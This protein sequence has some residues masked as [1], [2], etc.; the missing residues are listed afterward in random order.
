MPSDEKLSII[1][2]GNLLEMIIFML[3]SVDRALCKHLDKALY[4]NYISDV[5]LNIKSDSKKFW[6]NVNRSN[7]S[8]NL[9]NMM[10]YQGT[11]AKTGSEIVNFFA[12]HFSSVYNTDV[13][14]L[15]FIGSQSNLNFDAL[16]FS[17]VDI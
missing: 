10:I 8:N 2:N 6:R 4:H 1:S 17:F 11:N 14:D 13:A 7:N 9:P 5:R 16:K 12:S 3:N 15:E